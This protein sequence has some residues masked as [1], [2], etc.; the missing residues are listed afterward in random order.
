MEILQQQSWGTLLLACV[1]GLLTYSMG[2]DGVPVATY[3]G[4]RKQFLSSEIGQG[5]GAKLVLNEK[6]KRVDHILVA[7]KRKEVAQGFSETFPPTVNFLTGKP[8]VERSVVFDII[9]R[10]PKGETLFYFGI[11]FFFPFLCME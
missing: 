1:I 6:E 8:L 10:M 9:K 4:Q 2:V 3:L 11:F 5:V 7:V